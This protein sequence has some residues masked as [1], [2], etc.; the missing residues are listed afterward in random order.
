MKA[1][2]DEQEIQ[3]LERQRVWLD[4]A[5]ALR[6]PPVL[7]EH[8]LLELGARIGRAAAAAETSLCLDMVH[9]HDELYGADELNDDV[10]MVRAVVTN[11][12]HVRDQHDADNDDDDGRP[13]ASILLSSTS[14]CSLHDPDELHSM[15]QTKCRQA[16]DGSAAW[17]MMTTH[18]R[19]TFG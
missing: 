17:P 16:H 19:F 7:C 8:H 2:V 6:A 5:H 12:T 18:T 4:E 9:A 11:T 10:S 1:L 15:W 3:Y 13:C 14:R